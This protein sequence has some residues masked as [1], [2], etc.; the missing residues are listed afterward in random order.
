MGLDWDK[1]LLA[2]PGVNTTFALKVVMLPILKRFNSG[3][4]TDAL[5]QEIMNLE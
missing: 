4:R 1:A 2:T 3:E 5:Y